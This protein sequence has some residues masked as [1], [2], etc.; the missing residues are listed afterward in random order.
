MHDVIPACSGRAFDLKSGQSVTVTDVEGGQVADFF[1]VSAD[2]PEEFLS[3]AVT[4]DCNESLQIGTGS[5]IYTNLYHPMFEIVAD[6]VGRHDLLFPSCRP[7]MYDFF[8]HNGEGHPNC[9]DNINGALKEKRPI[10]NPVN[11]FMNTHVEPNGKVIIEA[12]VSKAGDRITLKALMN[13]KVG[14]AACSVSESKTNS[15][16]CTAIAV[17]LGKQDEVQ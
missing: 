4:I 8:Y 6:D 16:R 17:K 9:Y 3:T 12:P 15:R 13:V 7:E 11:L 1:A 2:N 10:I 14:I 5:M